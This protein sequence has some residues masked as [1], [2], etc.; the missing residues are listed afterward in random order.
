M[1]CKFLFIYIY[2]FSVFS[3]LFVYRKVFD[4]GC[5]VG[6]VYIFCVLFFIFCHCAGSFIL[7]D[8]VNSSINL[9]FKCLMHLN[10]YLNLCPVDQD[11]SL[12][13]NCKQYQ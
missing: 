1:Q 9:L 8:S 7:Y 13:C 3:H 12:H 11:R 6:V 4:F 10:A 5:S 2:S